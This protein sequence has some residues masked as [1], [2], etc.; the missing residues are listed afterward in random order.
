MKSK[1]LKI[2]MENLQQKIISISFAL[3]INQKGTKPQVN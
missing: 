1:F 2:F 3:S